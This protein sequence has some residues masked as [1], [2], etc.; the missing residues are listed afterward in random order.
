L[1]SLMTRPS[2][3]KSKILTLRLRHLINGVDGGCGNSF[4]ATLFV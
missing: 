1:N 3:T 2:L 4:A